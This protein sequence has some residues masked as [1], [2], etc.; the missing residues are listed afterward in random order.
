MH[1]GG[2]TREQ[3]FWASTVAPDAAQKLG[4]SPPSARSNTSDIYFWPSHTSCDGRSSQPES[5]V[6]SPGCPCHPG[7]RISVLTP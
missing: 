5:S 7:W 4:P 2:C 3:G 6:V 1:L